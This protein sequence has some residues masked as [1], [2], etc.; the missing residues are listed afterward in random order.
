MKLV[1]KNITLENVKKSKYWDL[2]SILVWN[3]YSEEKYQDESAIEI[4]ENWYGKF[5][6]GS[7]HSDK[8]NSP[9]YCEEGC[10]RTLGSIVI[11]F[12]RSDYVT[13]IY[14]HVNGDISCFGQYVS[15]EKESKSPHYDGAQR[16]LTVTNWMME[17][18]FIVVE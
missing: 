3:H 16:N 15:A 14:I 10:V 1:A 17:N 2:I 11:T 9:D 4:T 8:W 5:S 18:N 6:G 12:T 13:Y 7:S